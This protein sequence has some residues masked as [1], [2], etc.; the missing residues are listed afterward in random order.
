[1]TSTELVVRPDHMARVRALATAFVDTRRS[2]ETRRKY[3]EHL[4]R[5][6]VWCVSEGVDP[7][8]ARHAHVSAWLT[9]LQGRGDS[10]S[11]RAARLAAVGSWYRWLL[12]E[13]MVSRNPATLLPEERPQ[14][15]PRHTPA[16]SP[17]QAEALLRAADADGDR[18]SALIALM[19]Y[20]GARIGELLAASVSDI[21]QESGQTVLRIM[22]KGRKRRN[23]P[24]TTAVFVRLRRYLDSRTDVSLLPS[25][26]G[27]VGAGSVPLLATSTGGRLDP[28]QVRRIL[29]RCAKRAGLDPE[30]L[31]E[32]TPHSTRATYATA[33]LAAGTPLRDVQYALGHQ[34]PKTTEG[35]DRSSLHA[36]RHPSF[37]LAGLIRADDI[38]E[39]DDGME[40]E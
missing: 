3:A 39:A 7:L 40:P 24:V 5:W 12:R 4:A 6:L 26:R 27:Q 2:P 11:T 37:K 14:P 13:E 20:T 32:L 8:D 29:L 15:N 22:G 18:S 16:L 31:A 34:D 25:V 19:L 21:A 23:L 35:Y 28:K 1:M 10:D 33:N 30:V 38:H 36:D 9:D 17:P